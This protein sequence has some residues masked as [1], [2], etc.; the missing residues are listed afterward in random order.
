MSI[1]AWAHKTV[2]RVFGAVIFSCGGKSYTR[3]L[4]SLTS[5]G[6]DGVFVYAE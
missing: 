5:K 4:L 3:E 1:S 2:F 6:K